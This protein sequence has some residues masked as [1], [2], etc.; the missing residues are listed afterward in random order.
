VLSALQWY[1]Y[2][3]TWS[4]AADQVINYLNGAQVGATFTG[5]GTWAGSL[6]ATRTVLANGNANGV[7]GPFYGSMAHT[8]V[9]TTPLAPSEIAALAKVAS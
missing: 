8:A 5:L 9:W 6:S 4:L 3:L 7:D 1:S 2:A